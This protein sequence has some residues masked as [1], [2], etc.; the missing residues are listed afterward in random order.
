LRVRMAG[1]PNGSTTVV[2]A[3]A[4]G[5]AGVGKTTLAVHVAHQLRA[6]FPDGQLYVNLRG[7]EAQALAPA[8]V[9]GRFLRALGVE[10]QCLPPDV[11]SRAGLYRSLLAD[12]R[13]LV[14]LDNAGDEAQ[15]PP[16]LPAR[17]GNAVLVTSRV[18]LAGLTPAEVI[19][20]EVLPPE[21]AVELLGKIVG[22]G[23]VAAE[24]G[25]ASQLAALCGYLPL[26]LRIVGARLAAKPHWRIQRLVDRLAAPDRRPGRPAVVG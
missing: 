7:A 15:I 11:E 25:A 10:G 5:T 19:D 1:R 22:T 20:L 2:I 17:A 14:V 4:V 26:A 6:K 12:R 21:Q 3:G 23:R 8:E 16:L 24:S 9:L 13:K 18:R